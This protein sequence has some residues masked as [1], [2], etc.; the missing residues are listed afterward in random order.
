MRLDTKLIHTGEDAARAQGSV[1][2]PIY[3]TATYATQPGVAYDDIQYARLNNTPNHNALHEKIAA[4]A[5]GEACIVTGSGMAAISTALLTVLKAG[6]HFLVQDCIYGG[7]H[8]LLK[9]NLPAAGI[10]HTTIDARDPSSWQALLRPETKA[11]YVEAITNPMLDVA[12][13]REIVAFAKEHDLVSLIDNTFCSPAN[14]RSLDIGFDIELHSATKYLNGHSDIVAGC[15]IGKK[16]T[17]RQITHSLNH[18]GGCLDPHACFLLHRG[19]KT[20]SLRVGRQNENGLALAGFLEFHPGVERVIYPGLASHPDHCRAADLFVGCGGVVGFEA[21]GGPEA[22]DRLIE[23]LSLPTFAPS[24]GGVETLITRPALTT[25]SGMSPE[26]RSKAGI[27][28]T[29]VRIA[30]GIEAAVDL[31]DDFDRALRA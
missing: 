28:D 26:D 7:T 24:L 30:V 12:C 25:H 18:L 5:G 15:A 27:T 23:N 9:E 2:P 1:A 19:L 13:L 16:D 6:D 22:A 4:I 17:I 3:Q 11:I 21:C 14:F 31:C 29:L 10:T 20:L 8:S